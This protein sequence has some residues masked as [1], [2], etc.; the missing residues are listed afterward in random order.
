MTKVSE[1]ISLDT[2]SPEARALMGQAQRFADENKHRLF[3]PAHLLAVLLD[4]QDIVQVFKD[5]GVNTVSLSSHL[6]GYT[7]KFAKSEDSSSLSQTMIDLIIR[8]KSSAEKR[9]VNTF[10]LLFAVAEERV[11]IAAQLWKNFDLNPDKFRS[12]V[13]VEKVKARD[14]DSCPYLT[15]LSTL[16]R[17]DKLDTVIG[18]DNEVRRLIQIL[19]RRSKNHPLLVGESGVGKKTIVMSL[20][21]RIHKK[22][23]PSAFLDVTVVQLNTSAL[24]SGAKSRGDVEDRIREALKTLQGYPAIVY[25]RSLE[26]LLVQGLNLNLTDLFGMIFSNRNLRVVS[27]CSSDGLKKIAEKEAN[28]IREFTSV[29]VEPTSAECAVEVLRG[30][31]SRYER[32]HNIKIGEGAINLAVKLAKRYVQ[33]RFLPESAIDLLD[34]AASNR[35]M[36]VTGVPAK[37]D[38][39]VSRLASIKAQLTGLNGD[40][41][42]VSVKAR[43]VLEKEAK[44]VSFALKSQMSDLNSKSESSRRGEAILSEESIA[45]VLGEWTGIPVNKFLEGETEKLA[46]M[47]EKLIKR[48]I[49]QNEAI[50]AVSK[51]V[52]RS[53][54]GLR[55]PGKPIGSFMFLGSSGVGKT[56]TAK[57][58]AEFLFDD[59]SAMIRIDCSEMQERHMAQR[60]IGSPPGYQGSEEGGM[61]TEA[62]RKRPYCVLLFDEIEKAHPD[63]FNLLLQVLDDGRLTD[64][65][66]R[67]ADFSNTIVILTSNIG[68]KNILEQ[69]NKGVFDTEEGVVAMKDMLQQEMVKFLRPEFINRLDETIVFRPLAKEQLGSILD[70]QLNR[71]QKMLVEKEI[72]VKVTAEAKAQLVD[73]GY[74]PAYGARPLKRAILRHIQD[75]LAE[76]MVKGIYQKGSCVRVSFSKNSFILED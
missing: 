15:N 64:G 7:S 11:G 54:L 13:S 49:G 30:V 45:V 58:L 9:S 60:L 33:D 66:G 71:L 62:V 51:S 69:A 75:P 14:I 48:V 24:L 59:E 35:M 28:L 41:D 37:L 21:D 3:E 72:T 4:V 53:Y 22:H 70:I 68:S 5:L 8:V 43:V 10:D 52:R 29:N 16:A 73:I 23:V 2:F 56:E 46:S 1:N 12:A 55:D 76:A 63:V 18:R 6:H 57:A 40:D 44:D 36:E 27:S 38:R 42:E 47:E 20:V 67:T 26:K 31:A 74:E 17:K 34:E 65:R 19:G 61:L 39:A 25:V 32:H 50:R